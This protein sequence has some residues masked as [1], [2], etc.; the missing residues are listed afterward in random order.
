MSTQTL[1]LSLAPERSCPPCRDRVVA[2]VRAQSGVLEAAADGGGQALSVTFDERCS[3]DDVRA[4]LDEARAANASDFEHHLVRLSGMD[5]ADCALR[6]ESATARIPQ[7]TSVDVSL[8]A[9]RMRLELFAGTDLADVRE[10]VEHLGYGFQPDDAKHDAAPVVEPNTT[11]VLR[12]WLNGSDRVTMLSGAALLLAAAA[13]LAGAGRTAVIAAYLLSVLIGGVSIGRSGVRAAIAT[14]A[15][16]MNLL[17]AIA[18]LGAAAIGAWT[19]ASLVVVLFSVGELLERRAVGRAREQLASLVALA[20]P[21]ARV[22]RAHGSHDHEVEIEA[23]QLT[24]GDRIVIRPGERIAADGTIFDGATTIDQSAVTGESVPADRSTGDTVFAGTLNGP[25]R[26]VVTVTSEAGSSTLDRIAE[27]VREA[28]SQRSSSE[29]WVTAFARRYTPA[30][31]VLALL[32]ATVLPAVGAYSWSTGI[33]SALALLILA[34]PCALVLSTPVTIVSALGRASQAGVLVK[35]GVF[36]E[37]AAEIQRV[38][39]DK[40]GTLTYGRP[41][42]TGI[43]RAG[44]L[45]EIEILAAAAAVEAGSEH[46]LAAAIVEHARSKGITVEP[47]RDMAATVGLGAAGE[48]ANGDWVRV[49]DSRMFPSLA[50]QVQVMLDTYRGRGCTA[51]LVEIAG[52]MAGVIA[53]A[54]RARP[55]A[56]EAILQLGQLGITDTLMLSGD[57]E[58]A[59]AAVAS[60]VGIARVHARLLPED[61]EHLIA[62]LPGRTAMVGDGINDAPALARA[63]LGVAMGTGG[64]DTAIEVADVALIGDDPRKLPEL[65]GLARWTRTV[66]QQNIAFS[67]GTKFAAAILLLAGALPLWGAVATDVGAS[68][69]VVANGLRVARSAPLGASRKLP[70]LSAR[71]A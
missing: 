40:T 39:F 59:A 69:I 12:E 5:C 29:R 19:E 24:P 1:R 27:L 37:Q 64:S 66:V 41:Q 32:V 48:I 31:V 58:G 18:V 53:L 3:A 63:D 7:V 10:R 46:P 30:V 51:V 23:T 14:R 44:G 21:T 9:E 33:Y 57:H 65:I 54:D 16:D 55:E 4:R 60:D 49:G 70:L 25:A 71:P 52:E 43:G 26:I 20:P 28:Q 56:R 61:K 22:L 13:D 15:P 50:P 42:V 62:S 6:I 34:C 2:A 11:G 47:A 35:G 36:L 8:P 68:L 38:A 45:G 67:L 17:M